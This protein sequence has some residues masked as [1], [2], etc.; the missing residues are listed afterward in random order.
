MFFHHL[1]ELGLLET[2]DAC[3][4]QFLFCVVRFLSSRA[5]RCQVATGSELTANLFKLQTDPVMLGVVLLLVLMNLVDSSWLT[6]HIE[7]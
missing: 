3:F 5:K 4:R 2:C 1:V 6:N 7:A